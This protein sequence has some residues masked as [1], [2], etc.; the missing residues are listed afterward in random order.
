MDREKRKYDYLL[1]LLS[2][3]ILLGAWIIFSQMNPKVFP[4]PLAA[5]ERLVKLVERPVMKISIWGHIGISLQRVLIALAV[6]TVLGV[7]FGLVTG[8]CPRIKAAFNPL[9]VALRPI[10]PIAWIP[11]IILWFGIGEFPKVLL[12][13]I[14][15]FFP[16]AQNTMAGVEMVD[17][18]Y[19]KV[20]KIYKANTWNMLRHIVFPASMPAIMAG[21]KISLSSGWMVVVAA[22]MLASKSGLG[23]LIIR[24]QESFDIALVLVGMVLIGL[25]GAAFSIVFTFIERWICPWMTK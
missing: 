23:F 10:P 12:V 8:W 11:L 18:M 9:F 1:I 21:I 20:G 4:T 22:E 16:I 2:I 7:A 15:A 5:W 24:G 3:A 17:D 19:L 6:A 14:G 13:F 25:I